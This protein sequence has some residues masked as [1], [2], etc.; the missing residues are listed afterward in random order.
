MNPAP[1]PPDAARNA[2]GVYWLRSGYP[3][4]LR[5]DCTTCCCCP[6]TAGRIVTNP[7]NGAGMLSPAKRQALFYSHTTSL[8]ASF[9]KLLKSEPFTFRTMP[10]KLPKAGIYLFSDEGEHL[11]VGRTSS[12]RRRLQQHCRPSSSDNSSPFAFRLAREIRGVERAS[13][14]TKGSRKELLLDPEFLAAFME[15]KKRVSAMKIRVLEEQDDVRQTLLEVYIALGVEARHN[16]FAN[17]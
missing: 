1:T 12:M 8:E 14:K 17:H 15:S 6:S 7:L 16:I 2:P 9:L 11:Y 13:Y 3:L 5:V 4:T 10:A